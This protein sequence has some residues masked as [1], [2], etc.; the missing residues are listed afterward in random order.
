MTDII[1]ANP[2]DI[3]ENFR[4]AYYDQ[5]KFPMQIGS[6]EYILSS[7]FTYVLSAYSALVNQSYKNQVLETASGEFLDNIGKRYGLTRTP[8]AFT[9]PW[10]EGY[11]IINEN[12][13]IYTDPNHTD[14]VFDEHELEINIGSKTFVNNT[15]VDVTRNT[16]GEGNIIP[17]SCRFV[18]TQ[19][20]P[21]PFKN[22]E[23]KSTYLNAE[24]GSGNLAFD[25]ESAIYKDFVLLV[26]DGHE[27][28]DEEFRKYIKENKYRYNPGMA[29]AFESVA[30]LTTPYIVDARCRTQK[31]PGFIPGN[32]DL[33]VK[34]MHINKTYP[35][36]ANMYNLVR[37][38]DLDA[39]TSNCD[40]AG[41][42]T[43]GQLLNV[44]MAIPQNDCRRYTFY[45]AP[46]YHT[47]TYIHLYRLKFNAS[48]GWL[49]NHLKIGETF[50][51]SNVVQIMKQDLSTLSANLMDF[52]I[53]DEAS[54][55]YKLFNKYCAL[56]IYGTATAN[57]QIKPSVAKAAAH[58]VSAAEYVFLVTPRSYL[59]PGEE[60]PQMDV[61][62]EP[63][64]TNPNIYAYNYA[65]FDTLNGVES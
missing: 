27:L 39:I 44:S 35:A 64:S 50:I 9:N 53:V 55:E 51:A 60:N 21:L 36:Q 33:F 43:V 47:E 18:C 10:F 24:D 38:Q 14:H 25:D 34:P 11:F 54:D 40:R 22:P 26:Q 32:V 7:V 15:V 23:F 45:I 5:V 59:L 52:G 6:E 41:I 61:R 16:D 1:N 17:F 8:E 30:K 20:A 63:I 29:G 49:N 58:E 37:T 31:D 48:L 46:E 19:S 2:T 42:I 4:N 56:P 65:E 12:S 62:P 13:D 28:T 3:L 57:G